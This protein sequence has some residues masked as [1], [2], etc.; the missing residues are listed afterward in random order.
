MKEKAVINQNTFKRYVW[1]HVG[2]LAVAML[3]PLYEWITSRLSLPFLRGCFLHDYL[4]VYCAF[5][6]GTRSV[7]A[8]LRFDF[9]AML[10]YNALVP[11]LLLALIAV[12]VIALMRLLRGEEKLFDLPRWC[13]IAGIVALIGYAIL[14]N[15]LMIAHGYDPVGDLGAF[16]H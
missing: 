1:L 10:Q 11:L 7:G 3:F 2:A 8:F 6:G 4:H 13:W 14:R 16:W 12:D 5:C 9:A 15:Y